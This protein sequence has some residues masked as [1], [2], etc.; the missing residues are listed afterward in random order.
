MLF[1]SSGYGWIKDGGTMQTRTRAL[2]LEML[3]K[4]T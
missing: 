3:S 2:Y 4:P 1:Y